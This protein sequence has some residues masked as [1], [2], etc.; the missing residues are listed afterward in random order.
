MSLADVGY[1]ILSSAVKAFSERKIPKPTPLPIPCYNVGR[2]I[3]D[4]ILELSQE[5][6]AALRS[7]I[8]S[9]INGEYED[10]KRTPMAKYRFASWG[11]FVASAISSGGL[12]LKKFDEM[13]Q[14][15]SL[16]IT[17]ASLINLCV[18]YGIRDRN[19]PVE[20]QEE[21]A[22]IDQY[23]FRK[24]ADSYN[25]E[26]IFGYALLDKAIEGLTSLASRPNL[27]KKFED[28]FDFYATLQLEKNQ[29]IEKVKKL[30]DE[31]GG[32]LETKLTKYET[33]TDD[34]GKEQTKT[35]YPDVTPSSWLPKINQSGGQKRLTKWV[36]WRE[37]EL[38]KIDEAF[39]YSVKLLN[40][41][42][43]NQKA[44]IRLQ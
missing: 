6:L 22:E 26:K 2:E 35:I 1:T 32:Y 15:V 11:L 5:E 37:K 38:K 24:I 18:A 40:Q 12:W 8:G 9:S 4:P 20:R 44:E 43:Q 3:Q 28:L 7:R 29:D 13:P 31:N 34:E 30:Y 36:D 21:Q 25:K 16:G 27:Y 39:E 14:A 23:S 19:S 10:G 33:Y 17:V 42:Y 41:S